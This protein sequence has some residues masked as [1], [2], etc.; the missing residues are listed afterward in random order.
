MVELDDAARVVMGLEMRA[1]E[2][3]EF[4]RGSVAM[5]LDRKRA[6]A[7]IPYKIDALAI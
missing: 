4:W 1:L 5:R 6:L 2:E 7:L 3:V